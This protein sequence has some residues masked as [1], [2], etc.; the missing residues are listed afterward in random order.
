MRR[1]DPLLD[2]L[3]A[4]ARE[5]MLADARLR[6]FRAGDVVF[7]EG[8]P[9][10][11]LHVIVA[12]HFSLHV[13]LDTGEEVMLRVLGQGEIFGEMALLT[14]DGVRAA[15]V[16]AVEAGVTQSV[17][18]RVVRDL[19]DRSPELSNVLLRLLAGK[20]RDAD[21]RLLEALFVPAEVR[22]LRRLLEV[23]ERYGP[24]PDGSIEIPLRQEDL[25][26]LAGT[27]RGT[28]NRVLRAEEAKGT[29]SLS[30]GRTRVL[31]LD[32]LAHAAR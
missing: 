6:R 20:V 22:V 10:R 31:R 18:R 17:D 15:T 14:E 26:A 32:G 7:R 5:A 12:G 19:L 11:D 21:Q 3:P 30:R 27:S 28:V 24:S 29:V 8:D 9:A 23:A 1:G 13:T 16:R 4:H 25:A 2:E